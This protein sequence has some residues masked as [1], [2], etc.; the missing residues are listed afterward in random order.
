MTASRE[1]D[2]SPRV[3]STATKRSLPNRLL[4]ALGFLV[5]FAFTAGPA[6][7]AHATAF[8]EVAP[9]SAATDLSSP[10]IEA[11][12]LG[13]HTCLAEPSVE[14]SES[15]PD[16]AAHASA[17]VGGAVDAGRVLHGCRRAI[18]PRLRSRLRATPG[19]GPP[20]A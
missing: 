13:D 20:L 11:A 8:A 12:P 5:A 2:H 10:A 6:P 18:A 7:V 1:R 3:S 4:G 15:E 16:E 19:R 14:S 9:S 17:V